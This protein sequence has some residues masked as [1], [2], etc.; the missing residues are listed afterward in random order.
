MSNGSENKSVFNGDGANLLAREI[1]K[2]RIDA[3][4]KLKVTPEIFSGALQPYFQKLADGLEIERSEKNDEKYYRTTNYVIDLLGSMSIE[5]IAIS[6]MDALIANI[7]RSEFCVKSNLIFMIGKEVYMQYLLESIRKNKVYEKIFREINEQHISPQLKKTKLLEKSSKKGLGKVFV[8]SKEEL[9]DIYY[10]IG[11]IL[12]VSIIKYC[13]K[14]IVEQKEIILAK[15]NTGRPKQVIKVY[16]HKELLNT[17]D[18]EETKAIMFARVSRP[19]D[20]LPLD[21]TS[22]ESGGISHIDVLN[23]Y[24]FVNM[25]GKHKKMHFAKRLFCL[26]EAFSAANTLQRVPWIINQDVLKV[27]KR[28][29]MFENIFGNNNLNNQSKEFE[30]A[31]DFTSA[32]C[33][34]NK[35]FYFV[36]TADYR[37][38]LYAKGG[39]ATPQGDDYCKAVFNFSNGHSLGDSGE[40]ALKCMIAKHYGQDNMSRENQIKWFE[41]N[42]DF[43]RKVGE[44]PEETASHWL[45]LDSPYQFV[46]YCVEWVKYEKSGLGKDYVSHLSYS[47]D[48][49]CS[50]FQILSA[51]LKDEEG[52]AL[53]NISNDVE[54]QDIYLEILNE[55]KLSLEESDSP[56][57]KMWLNF[58]LT[59][60]LVKRPVM[61]VPYSATL[62]SFKDHIIEHVKEN[63]GYS[64]FLADYSTL[65]KAAHFLAKEISTLAKK[66]CRGIEVMDYLVQMTKIANKQ[67]C[68]IT[69]QTR[70]GWIAIQAEYEPKVKRVCC[71]YRCLSYYVT[72]LDD[73]DKL[74]EKSQLLGISP[75]VIHSIDASI[76]HIAVNKLAALGI[77]DISTTHDCFSVPLRYAEVVNR[78]VREAFIEALSGDILNDIYMQV[79]EMVPDASQVPIP[80]SKGNLNINDILKNEY[81]YS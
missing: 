12:Y 16:L 53:V 62:N 42:I 6:A 51:L 66:C 38:R 68:P 21:W 54:R 77:T 23:P 28:I 33:D 70:S 29:L 8:K 46:A 75:N 4:F 10:R 48:A 30:R 31:I 9:E 17:L 14:T 45:N 36:H 56:Y 80:P 26:E 61:R 13:E 15:D 59:R 3:C 7:Y 2:K 78:V 52:G 22:L 39:P 55:L 63:N 49:S 60:D 57:A 69:W 34:E 43:I 35:P 81:A 18:L 72:K 1:V 64:F 50:G 20:V 76:V 47:I 25:R 19:L 40:S 65:N 24:S 74:D 11:H 41:E 58:T 27:A 44:N 71:E 5:K 73:T 32:L 37:G 79:C 67:G